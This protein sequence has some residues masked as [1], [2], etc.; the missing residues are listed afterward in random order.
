MRSDFTTG[1]ALRLDE[2]PSR[3]KKDWIVYVTPKLV[4]AN[5]G[6]PTRD[7][8]AVSVSSAQLIRSIHYS[9]IDCG[10]CSGIFTLKHTL[11]IG[12]NH[13]T[14]RNQT[15][16]TEAPTPSS[17]K[18]TV[19]CQ[20]CS[21]HII[22]TRPLPP[23]VKPLCK[24]CRTRRDEEAAFKILGETQVI[25]ASQTQPLP[26]LKPKSSKKQ[27]TP[28]SSSLI[29]G[30]EKPFPRAKPRKRYL[31]TTMFVALTMTLLP[32][33]YISM[34]AAAAYGLAKLTMSSFL[35]DLLPTALAWTIYLSAILVMTSLIAMMLK[36][37]WAPPSRRKRQRALKPDQAPVLF[38]FV[39]SIAH[40]V[41][42]PLPKS[43]HVVL[44]PNAAAHF[45]RGLRGIRKNELVLTI[46]LPLLTSMNLS[47][48]AG[49]IAHELGH[50]SQGTGMRL[51]S[52]VIAIHD[53]FAKI[54]LE[55]DAFDDELQE[56]VH[57]DT[58]VMRF[59]AR[60]FLTL[61][62]V[63]RIMF[64][65]LLVWAKALY[66]LL[67]RQLE[68]DADSYE[69]RLVGPEV[70]EE[71]LKTMNKLQLSFE[72]VLSE[73][74]REAS[75]VRSTTY[76]FPENLPRLVSEHSKRLSPDLLELVN[77][78][79][80]EKQTCWFDSHPSDGE[81]LEAACELGFEGQYKNSYP[82]TVLIP[83]FDTIAKKM[84]AKSFASLSAWL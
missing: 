69:C 44:E 4:P 65:L 72:A 78:M 6:E 29:K 27:S 59:A 32:A 5:V 75:R 57:S 63:V 50:F 19:E 49:I 7:L 79:V 39:Q 70:F 77:H 67:S 36:P 11:K 15:Q 41:N 16:T 83:S 17:A 60:F 2:N 74:L 80:Y 52:I 84:T 3:L 66:C 76:E 71:S 31:L 14:H 61:S 56:L 48:F 12:T 68:F 30:L 53:W 26:A 64:W 13:V 40:V 42:A 25:S 46:G 28:R 73:I 37:L 33:I 10:N 18:Q 43:I 62:W 34:V 82:A 45:R 9:K 20:Q 1:L 54:V 35:F 58:Y 55:R 23:R 22:F 21:K 8:S 47:Q 51:R 81:R 38:R 24:T